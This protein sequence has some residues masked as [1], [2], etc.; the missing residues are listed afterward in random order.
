MH[1]KPAPFLERLVEANGLH[2]KHF[3][4]WVF[5]PGMLFH[6]MLKWWGSGGERPTPHEGI[7][8]CYYRNRAGALQQLGAAAMIPVMYA[9]EVV[10]VVDDHLGR[11]IIVRHQL[12]DGKDKRLHTFYGHA[13]ELTSVR[14]G[15]LVAANQIIA[16]LS[17]ARQKNRAL[18]SHLHLTAAWVPQGHPPSQLN[19]KRLQGS[20]VV[21]VDPLMLLQCSYELL[22]E[23]YDAAAEAAVR[24]PMNRAR[25]GGEH[26]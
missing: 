4:T 14:I 16:T 23:R 24:P 12:D 15:S 19:W 10:Q 20:A 1:L 5:H 7:D 13:A 9:G 22:E 6:S 26:Y 8:I 17:D 21:L 3:H 2:E 25:S 18:A 11:T